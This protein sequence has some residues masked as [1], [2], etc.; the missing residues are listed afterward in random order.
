MTD[1]ERREDVRETTEPS[2]EAHQN[3][4]RSEEDVASRIDPEKRWGDPEARWGNPEKDLP[5]IPRVRI[6]GED[7]NTET[8]ETGEDEEVPE[9]S[10]DIDPEAARLFWASVILANI[11][12]AG[13]A[14]GAMLIY[15]RGQTMVGGGLVL[16]GVGSLVRVYYTHKKFE[17]GDWSSDDDGDEDSC[18]VGDNSDDPSKRNR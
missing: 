11:G 1:D 7:A 5:N 14:V 18:E 17:R 3:A 15:F 10:A 9:F 13:V 8:E 16:L 4:E 12:V 6:P 2:A